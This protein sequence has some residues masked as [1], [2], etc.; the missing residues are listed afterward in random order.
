MACSGGDA[1]CVRSSVAD[2][3]ASWWKERILLIELI[4]RLLSYLSS[5]TYVLG[6]SCGSIDH[7]QRPYTRLGR[8]TLLDTAKP[9]ADGSYRSGWRATVELAVGVQSGMRTRL[10]NSRDLPQP[11]RRLC[12]RLLPRAD[13]MRH[14][15]TPGQC[16]RSRRGV[17]SSL[18]PQVITVGSR[19]RQ[20]NH[21]TG[22]LLSIV[23]IDGIALPPRILTGDATIGGRSLAH[24]GAVLEAPKTPLEVQ[25]F[26]RY[27]GRLC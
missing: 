11:H 16:E 21:W 17:S 6:C 14:R 3:D 10:T 15:D 5:C 7:D 2:D 27:S 18:P 26:S 12:I 20:S 23:S 1:T 25:V 9:S 8:S 22:D 4:V 19:R 13:R 24:S